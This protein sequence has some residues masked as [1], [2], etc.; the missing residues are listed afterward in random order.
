VRVIVLGSNGM[1]GSE[2]VRTLRPHCEV[3]EVSRKTTGNMTDLVQ[4]GG[5]T[6]FLEPLA[7]KSDD[8]V[9]NAMGVVKAR[10][11]PESPTSILNAILINSVFPQQLAAYCQPRGS[12]VITVLTDCVFSG[13]AGGYVES[14]HHDPLDVYGKTKSLGEVESDI[15]M[16]LRVSFLGT[17]N[18]GPKMLFDWFTSLPINSQ[19]EG[20][21]SHRWNG[22]TTPAVARVV[23]SVIINSVFSSGTFHLVPHYVLTK[24]ELLL[25]LRDVSKRS[26]IRVVK[27]NPPKVDRSL[28]TSVPA[29]SEQLW[30][31]SHGETPSSIDY[32]LEELMERNR[33]G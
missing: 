5:S 16:N 4:S 25:K 10:I 6:D 1:L 21:E 13:R 24:Y 32:A 18:K 9:V 22:T 14:S 17:S 20:Y 15:S 26:D 29:V 31:S 7:L 33:N 19:V 12:R 27:S 28:A 11:E 23:E 8:Y 30:R 2:L 3:V